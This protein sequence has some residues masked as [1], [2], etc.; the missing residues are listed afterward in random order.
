MRGAK[1]AGREALSTVL[2][3]VDTNVVVA[4]LITAEAEAPTACILDAML[5]GRLRFFL[6]EELLAEYRAVLLRPK[7]AKLHALLPAEIDEILVRLASG[8][9]VREPE[10]SPIGSRGDRHLVALLAVETGAL[11]VSGDA[12]LLSKVT[13]RGRSPRELVMGRA[14]P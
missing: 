10:G 3:V 5:A 11:L 13:P 4:G 12:R 1:T 2:F 8:A 9:V 14:K 7:I 6:S